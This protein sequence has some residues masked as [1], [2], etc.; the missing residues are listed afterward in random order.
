VAGSGREV[1]AVAERACVAEVRLWGRTVGAVAEIE[2][3]AV[4]FE[5]DEAFRKTGLEISPV[6]LPLATVGP[7]QFP[8]LVRQEAFLGLPGVLAD[9]L[10][11]R[12]G[13]AII[14]AYFESRGRPDAAMS[15]VQRLLYIGRRAMGALEFH[16][17]LVVRTGPETEALEIADLVRAARK[18]VQGRMDVTIPEIMR[19]GSSAGGARPKAIILWNRLRDEVRSAFA[20]RRA[21]D[22]HWIIKFDGVGELEAPDPKPRP[23]NRIEHAYSQMAREA[24]IFVPETHLLRERRLAHFVTRRF[25]REGGRR[26]HLH[27]VGGMEHSDF[28]QPG[29][30]SYEQYLR[31]VMTLDLG[32]P[33]LEEAFRR[34]CF[35]IL[36]VNQDDHVKNLAFLMDESGR[37]SLAPAFDVTFARGAGFTRRHQM[38]LAGK[39]DRFEPG[40]LLAVGDRFGLRTAGREIIE[41][42]GDALSRWPEFAKA[43]GVPP[44]STRAIGAALRLSLVRGTR[45]AQ[46]KRGRSR[47]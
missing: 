42:I 28:N 30:Y 41:R 23:Y 46:R 24:G 8:E 17:P 4:V 29:T 26:L 39:R 22:E 14:R 33:A 19:L 44:E 37:W 34:A 7:Q 2:S 9:A 38:T 40:D 10:P 1:G 6:M 16:P 35:N 45:A 32:Y 25:D 43:S 47:G 18:V 27:S 3:G 5:Y 12:F 31:L 13:N 36:A 11:D 15:P 21:G 20:T